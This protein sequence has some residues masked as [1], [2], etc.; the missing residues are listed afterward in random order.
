[1]PVEFFTEPLE[2]NDREI[3]RPRHGKGVAECRNE[4][5]VNKKSKS[6]KVRRLVTAIILNSNINPPP[7]FITAI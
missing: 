4:G 2:A 6:L 1:L 5:E 7:K 3:S